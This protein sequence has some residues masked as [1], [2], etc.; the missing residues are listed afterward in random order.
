MEVIVIEK[1][2]LCFCVLVI[3][4]CVS[5]ITIVLCGCYEKNN[6]CWYYDN[7][8]VFC[9]EDNSI[10][11]WNYGNVIVRCNYG[12]SA[13]SWYYEKYCGFLL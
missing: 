4:W 11:C 10:V 8:T 7:S 5:V 1:R 13:V 12:N 2:C 9:C 3:L 6:V